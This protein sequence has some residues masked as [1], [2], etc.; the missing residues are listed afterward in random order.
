[1]FSRAWLICGL[2]GIVVG[3]GFAIY[4]ASW[5]YRSIPG[6][7]TIVEL[8]PTTSQEGTAI[9]YAPRFSFRAGDGRL[10]TVTSSVM[11]NPPEFQ[12]GEEVRV[13]YIRTDPT[14]AKLDYLWQL[15]L[16]SAVC[17]GLGALFAGAGFMLFRYLRSSSPTHVAQGSL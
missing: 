6:R 12:V 3:C 7:G 13:R 10:F 1:M 4:T 16:V 5:L 14:S 2:G 8:V 17:A 11:S 15:W 9:S